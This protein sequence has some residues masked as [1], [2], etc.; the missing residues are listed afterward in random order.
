MYTVPSRLIGERL[1]IRLYQDKLEAYVGQAQALT[2]PRTYPKPGESRAR[3]IDYKHVIRALAAKPQAFRYSQLRDDLLPSRAYKTLWEHAD[4]TLEKREACKW[5]VTVLR[6]AY[7]YDCESQLATE[8]LNELQGD[9][10]PDIKEVQT[11]FLRPSDAVSEQG[12]PQHDL[13]GY[14]DLLASV[15]TP[16]SAYQAVTL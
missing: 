13:A 8:L 2:L 4:R 14:D 16:S 9:K 12:A 11:R 6:L 15:S 3:R 5:I 10:L 7:E 1:Q